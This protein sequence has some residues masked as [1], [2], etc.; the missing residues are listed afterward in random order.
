M[1][2]AIV[3]YTLYRSF[4]SRKVVLAHDALEVLGHGGPMIEEWNLTA[5]VTEGSQLGSDKTA[6]T[7]YV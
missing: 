3:P 5:V 4:V 1:E 7:E 6:N 2:L